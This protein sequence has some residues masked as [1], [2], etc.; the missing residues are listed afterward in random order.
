MELSVGF[1]FFAVLFSNLLTRFFETTGAVYPD[2]LTGSKQQSPAH[3]AGR[4]TR[5][6]VTR[7]TEG[8]ARI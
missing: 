1:S 4:F 5:S 2:P 6:R 7:G 8:Y 3:P